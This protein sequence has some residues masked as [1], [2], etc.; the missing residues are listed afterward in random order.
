[1]KKV[2]FSLLMI[3]LI[4]QMQ[5]CIM[6]PIVKK[7]DDFFAKK[8]Y[9]K[10]ISAYEQGLSQ[11]NDTA[12]RKT[13][14]QKIAS[15]KGILTD[16]YLADAEAVYDR[17]E[18]ITVPII[19]NAIGILEQGSKWD[20]DQRR[21]ASKIDVYKQKKKKLLDT[22]QDDL[23]KAVKESNGYNYEQAEKLINGALSIDPKNQ[24]LLKEK[25]RIAVR[26]GH[27]KEIKAYLAKGDLEN[28]LT[29]FNRLSNAT[30]TGLKFSIFPL[31]DAFVS[32]ISEKVAD[33]REENKWHKA[34]SL[35]TRWDLPELDEE[36]NEVKSKASEYYY[37]NAK[38]SVESDDNYFKGYLYCIKANELNPKD[39]RIFELYKN[40]KDHVDKSMQRYIAIGSFDPPS[41]EPDAGK[42]FSDSLISYLYRVLPYGINIME[43]DKIDT[44]LKE[45]KS[46]GDIL[47]VNLIVTGTVSLF[48]V[49]TNVDKRTATIKIKVGEETVENPAFMQMFKLYGKDTALWPSVPPKTIKKERH[50]LLNYT[51]GTA[52]VKGFAKVSVRIFDT[53]KGAITFVKDFDASAVASCEFQDEVKEAGIRYVPM[54][55]PT[56]TEIK[57]QMRKKIVSEIA[58]IVQASFENREIRFLN[59]VNFY[60]DRRE[61][62]AALKPLAT[63]HLYCML[64]NI[65]PDNKTFIEIKRLIDNFFE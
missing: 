48:K 13:I 37:E 25:K 31:K 64:D 41:N 56:D 24:N 34:Y 65:K 5:G 54:S 27:F 1:M 62:E 36:L 16:H 35:L 9:Y 38:S 14:K 60:L 3:L 39:M 2:I 46:A 12:I 47:G 17:Q 53:K 44:I 40:V 30:S 28:A 52:Q 42:Q 49:D 22:I 18:K 26:R 19:N 10:A 29:S 55:L 57:E 21:I 45:Q 7:G 23:Q 20:D 43:R 8:N 11:T 59:Q 50:Q 61:D 63:G 15:I 33:L 32:L 6:P 58:K 51:K 4:I